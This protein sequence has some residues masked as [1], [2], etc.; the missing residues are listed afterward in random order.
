M[1]TYNMPAASYFA[2]EGVSISTLKHIR[3]TPAHLKHYLETEREESSAEQIIGTLVH[4]TLLEPE[5]PWP[6]IAE[7]TEDINLRTKEGKAWRAEQQSAGKIIMTSAELEELNRCVKACLRSPRVMELLGK[8]RAE[9]SIFESAH[10]DVGLDVAVKGRLDFVPDDHPVLIDIKAVR[11]ASPAAFGKAVVDYEWH[12]QAAWYLDLWNHEG[13]DHRDGF[14][15]IALE[16]PT[17]LLAFYVCPPD[18][19]QKGREDNARDLALYAECKRTN[20]WPGYPEQ[21]QTLTVPAWFK[22]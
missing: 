11:D 17:G 5:R 9:V 6:Q 22:R 2:A 3:P 14:L 4:Q 10:M 8:G 16:K 20:T 1:I 12:R 15:W 18:L 19:E 7:R 21:V 13:V